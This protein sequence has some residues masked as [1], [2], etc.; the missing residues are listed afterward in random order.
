MAR[1]LCNKDCYISGRYYAAGEIVEAAAT[2]SATFF[3][4]FADEGKIALGGGWERDLD[5][6]LYL[7]VM[8]WEDLTYPATGINPPGAAS[9]PTRNTTDGMFEFSKSA[10]NILAGV[11]HLPHRRKFGSPIVPH[12]HWLPADD[13]AGNIVWKFEYKVV[14]YDGAVPANYTAVSKTV[15]APE[16]VKHVVT[17][18]GGIAM[19]DTVLGTV[20]LWKLSRL[21]DNVA[22]T[23]DAIVKLMEFD[24]HFLQD[25]M[26]SGRET[27]K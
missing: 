16:A 1:F 17:T 25:S 9:D 15:A 7:P 24:I 8:G 20:I 6:T 2:P 13:T 12:I 22:N 4:A 10:E 21:G 14:P 18:F 26:G 19:T 3:S 27:E 5:N 23:Y 11:A